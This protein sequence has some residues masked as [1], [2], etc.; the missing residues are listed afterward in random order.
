MI[1]AL[2]SAAGRGTSVP[3]AAATVAS[4]TATVPTIK[5]PAQ[6]VSNGQLR[7][8]GDNMNNENPNCYYIIRQ[9]QVDGM[10]PQVI[11]RGLTLDEAQ[12]HCRD[13]ETS[14]STCRNN[15]GQARTQRVGEW[16]DCYEQA[17]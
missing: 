5:Q 7:T 2:L 12:A 14:S 17:T 3:L 8:L 1:G 16:F 13:P 11:K 9:Y 4:L 10:R 6:L 15:A